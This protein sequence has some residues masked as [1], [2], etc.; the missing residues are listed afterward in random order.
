MVT[1]STTRVNMEVGV[2]KPD[3]TLAL[4]SVQQHLHVGA[5][6]SATDTDMIQRKR[7]LIRIRLN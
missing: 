3:G 7:I 2:W 6:L 4:V 5:I 1:I